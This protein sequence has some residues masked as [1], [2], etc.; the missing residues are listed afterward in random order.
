M[1]RNKNKRTQAMSIIQQNQSKSIRE[2]VIEHVNNRLKEMPLEADSMYIV[3]DDLF[4][5][6]QLDPDVYMNEICRI[7]EDHGWYCYFTN[8]YSMKFHCRM[9][10]FRE[11]ITKVSYGILNN[12]IVEVPWTGFK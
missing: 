6:I 3:L 12:E 8:W 5:K 11:P 10:I 1:D 4:V 9:R 2:V 7:I